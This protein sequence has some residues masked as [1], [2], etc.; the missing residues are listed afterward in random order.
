M[1]AN[2]ERASTSLLAVVSGPLGRT[3]ADLR[4][5]LTSDRDDRELLLASA[6][7]S[8]FEAAASIRKISEALE[9]L[10]SRELAELSGKELEELVSAAADLAGAGS[11]DLS[12]IEMRARLLLDAALRA[13]RELQRRLPD[14]RARA[15]LLDHLEAA[16]ERFSSCLLYTSP[17]PRD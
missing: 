6:A 8:V 14:L 5:A 15:D 12:L 3:G 4:R 2:L 10:D 7:A 9:I 11:M 1:V 16:A 13:S 17:S